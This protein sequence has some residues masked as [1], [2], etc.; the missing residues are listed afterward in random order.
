MG[1]EK[2]K[3]GLDI[4]VEMTI[5][6]ADRLNPNF[7]KQQREDLIYSIFD[8][9]LKSYTSFNRQQRRNAKKLLKK[10][11]KKRDSE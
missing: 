5:G 4:A 10:A 3:S 7:D 1:L 9:Q 2:K 11:L 8:D 6:I